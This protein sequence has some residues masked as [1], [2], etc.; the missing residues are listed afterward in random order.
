MYC[1]C[2]I[3]FSQLVL[4]GNLYFGTRRISM[5]VNKSVIFILTDVIF[6]K[7]EKAFTPSLSDNVPLILC[8]YVYGSFTNWARQVVGWGNC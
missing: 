8:I 1:V 5:S 4:L 6:V 7:K 3:C 2:V